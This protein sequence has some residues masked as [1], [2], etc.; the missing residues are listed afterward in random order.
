[1][2]SNYLYQEQISLLS[3]FSNK[4]YYSYKCW[5]YTELCEAFTFLMENMY[6]EFEGMVFQQIVVILMGT[7]AAPLITDLI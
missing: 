5:T 7:N 4:K 3:F 1:M 2:I 6:A